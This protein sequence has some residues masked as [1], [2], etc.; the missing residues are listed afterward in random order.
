MIHPHFDAE[1][2]ERLLSLLPPASRAETLA[3]FLRPTGDHRVRLTIGFADPALQA[4]LEEVW[5]PYWAGMPPEDMAR[6]PAEFPG[7][8]LA[9][10]RRQPPAQ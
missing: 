3:T 2:L 6:E 4:A 7:R 10:R 1:A 8:E 5:Q 9:L